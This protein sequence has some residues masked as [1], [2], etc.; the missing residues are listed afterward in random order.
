[1][2]QEIEER[3]KKEEEKNVIKA[4]RLYVIK[5]FDKIFKSVRNCD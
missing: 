1:M 2:Y 4:K 3:V 5:Y